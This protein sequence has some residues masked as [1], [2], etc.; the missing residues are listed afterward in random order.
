MNHDRDRSSWKQQH[1]SGFYFVFQFLLIVCFA[2]GPLVGGSYGNVMEAN[3][4][5]IGQSNGSIN[6]GYANFIHFKYGYQM[7]IISFNI[8]W[9]N[10]PQN[11][12]GVDA[13]KPSQPGGK[14]LCCLLSGNTRTETESINLNQCY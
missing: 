14:G 12:K 10:Q 6:R 4:T 7:N 3:D 13:T 8:T 1:L 2:R 5:K 11:K 9:M